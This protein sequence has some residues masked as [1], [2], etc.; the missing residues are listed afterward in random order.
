MPDRTRQRTFRGLI[1]VSAALIASAVIAIALTILG[2][3][4]DA[5]HDAERDAGDIATLLAEQTARS[6]QA[7]DSALI[8]LQGRV[9]TSGVTTPAA[10]RAAFGNEAT[11]RLLRQQLAGLSQADVITIVGDD[12]RIISNSR[13][14]PT[15]PIDLSDRDYFQHAKTS[16]SA[17]LFIG[18][19]HVNRT[20]GI[21]A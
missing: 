21:P 8:E 2:L 17:E 5:I 11:F 7:I 6:V 9:A 18:T 1:A 15:R 20:T 10:F 12:G 13:A 4:G 3:H 19:P 16:R 14:F